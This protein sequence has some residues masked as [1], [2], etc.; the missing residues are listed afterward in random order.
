VRRDISQPI[1]VGELAAI[2]HMSPSSFHAMVNVLPSRCV[3]SPAGNYR[4]K[5]AAYESGGDVSA[6]LI[7]A[8]LERAE[9]VLVQHESLH[10][11]DT[12]R[13]RFYAAMRAPA[14]PSRA[15]RQLLADGG[16]Y[17]LLE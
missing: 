11:D 12:T 1:C 5:A 15:L 8:G 13:E 3:A 9:R 16:R 6:F 2:A 7:A 4:K 14:R 17:R 10:I